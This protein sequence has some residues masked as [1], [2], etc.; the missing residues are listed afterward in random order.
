MRSRFPIFGLNQ[1]VSVVRKVEGDDGFGGISTSSSTIYSSRKCR[2]TVLSAEAERQSYGEATGK[3]W[4]VIM[5]LSKAIELSDCISVP[6]GTY[7]NIQTPAGLDG[8]LPLKVQLTT[9]AG[10]K[11]LQWFFAD[12]KYSDADANNDPANNYTVVWT[13]S[14]WRF[15]DSDASLVVDFTGYA[16]S[17]NIFNLNWASVVG[18]SYAVTGQVGDAKEYRIIYLNHTTDERGHEHH[19]KLIV[20]FE[21]TNNEDE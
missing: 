6:Q 4:N 18:A 17:N 10:A 16:Q 2:I 3:R 5:E 9:P 12:Q 7:P 14:V 21:D 15:T 20:E 11:N 8:D 1:R 19:T 13:G